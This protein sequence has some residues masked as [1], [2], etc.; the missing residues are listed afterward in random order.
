[1][2]T[3]KRRLTNFDFS[4]DNAHVALVD[5]AANDQKIL[6]MKNFSNMTRFVDGKEVPLQSSGLRVEM[7]LE[8]ALMILTGIWPEDIELLTQSVKKAKNGPELIELV[9]LGMPSDLFDARRD[10]FE[11]QVKETNEQGMELLRMMALILDDFFSR[12]ISPGDS[13]SSVAG[14]SDLVEKTLMSKDTPAAPAAPAATAEP[15]TPAVAPDV[16]P[17]SV[18]KALDTAKATIEKQAAQL[19]QLEKRETARQVAAFV[20][21]AATFK[22]LGL[23]EV[24][25][26]EDAVTAFGMVL[27]TLSDAAPEAYAKIE[28]VLTKAVAT[29]DKSD[30]LEESGVDGQPA[31]TGDADTKLAKAVDAI[32]KSNPD[33]TYEQAVVKAL[34]DNP[35]LYEVLS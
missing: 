13:D 31:D 32:Q 33:I 23:P 27:K 7:S 11:M 17:E 10:L 8:D 24:A 18:Q 1:M 30:L 9:K 15:N 12:G 22:S 21:K 29:L 35:E 6:V 5:K 25:D 16:I 4:A 34:E 2:P 26:D 14:L 20:T 28:S 3:A 19:E